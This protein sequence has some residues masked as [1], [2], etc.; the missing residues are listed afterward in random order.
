[1][2]YLDR[3][4]YETGVYYVIRKLAPVHATRPDVEGII[5]EPCALAK[6]TMVVIGCAKV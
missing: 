1:M 3:F 6:K 2:Y 4:E 5:I